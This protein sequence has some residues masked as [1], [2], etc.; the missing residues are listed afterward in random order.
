MLIQRVGGTI[1]LYRD[2]GRFTPP[3]GRS[4]S[5]R[6][7]VARSSGNTEVPKLP[8]PFLISETVTRS[9]PRTIRN[10]IEQQPE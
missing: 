9:S 5:T 3:A 1:G 10:E 8:L 7:F 2:Q 6:D 4:P